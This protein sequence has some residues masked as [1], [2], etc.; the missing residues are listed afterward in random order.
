MGMVRRSFMY[1]DKDMFKS[2]F[3]AIIR[4]HL[5]Y[6]APVWN[7]HFKKQINLIESVQRRAT[8]LIPGLFNLSYKERLKSVKLPTLEYRRYRGDMIELYKMTHHL[9]DKDATQGFLRYKP[10][11]SRG[12]KFNLHKEYCKKDI[13][14]YSFRHRTTDQWNNL[15]EVITEAPTLNSFK[16]RIDKLWEKDDVMYD[17]DVDLFTRTS[18]RRNRYVIIED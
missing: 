8:K 17:P 3:T 14:R 1:L 13:R 7:P 4:P 12:H 5:E 9:Y 2:L 11:H 10:A 16:S 6:G 15:P 18:L